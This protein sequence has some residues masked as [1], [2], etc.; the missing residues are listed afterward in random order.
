MVARGGD[1]RPLRTRPRR[2][3]CSARDRSV[4]FGAIPCRRRTPRGRCGRHRSSPPGHRAGPRPGC[5][6][7]RSGGPT[8]RPGRPLAPA[9]PRPPPGPARRHGRDVHPGACPRRPGPVR[10]RHRDRGRHDL[11]GGRHPPAVHAPVDVQAAGLRRGPRRA[12]RGGRPPAHRRRAHR[13]GV[14]RHHPRPGHR[15]APSTRWSTPAPSPPRAWSRA[16]TTSR[17]PRPSSRPSPGSPAARS[18]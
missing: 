15:H 17:R 3:P 7:H 11:R 18:T 6:G 14:Q 12:G 1:P 10:H 9:H 16:R 4:A 8:T 5:P 2:A 13:R